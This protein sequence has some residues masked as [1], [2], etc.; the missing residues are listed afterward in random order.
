MESSPRTDGVSDAA[1]RPDEGP[2]RVGRIPS[3]FCIM[4]CRRIVQFAAQVVDVNVHDV[5]ASVSTQIPNF[6]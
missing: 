6:L 5:R 1:N 3:D 2:S 4:W